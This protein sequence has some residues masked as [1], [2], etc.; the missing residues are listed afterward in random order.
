MTG[1]DRGAAAGGPRCP[2]CGAEV[3]LNSLSCGQCGARRGAHGWE[4]DEVYD[5]LDLPGE[6]NDDFDYDD[7]VAREFGTG[8]KTGWQ[9]WPARRRFWWVV[10]VITLIA[11]SW[12]A[13][14]QFGW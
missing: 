6:E 12:L 1:S 2:E 7:F 14:W 10:A 9:S 8:P 13:L 11:F 4:Q 3:H 5:G